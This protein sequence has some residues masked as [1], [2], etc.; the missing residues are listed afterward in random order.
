MLP[1]RCQQESRDRS[2]S[3]G[4]GARIG[5]GSAT[6]R[7]MPPFRHHSASLLAVLSLSVALPALATEAPSRQS[8]DDAWWTGP[9]I[10]N[11]AVTLPQGH[12]LIEPYLY[13]V[14][15]DDA[16]SYGSLTFMLYGATDALTVG[17]VPVFG[18]NKGGDGMRSAG[19][20]AA[21]SSVLLQYRL[22]QYREGSWLPAV[23]LQLQ[24]TLPTGKYDQLELGSADGFGGG[25]HSTLLQLNSQTYFW[26]PNG[27]ILRMR[28]NL[29]ATRSRQA[30]LRD[31]SVYGTPEGFRGHARPGDSWNV[32][33]AWEY[34]WTRNW[35]LA[36]DLVYRH[37]DS[38]RISGVIRDS[39][40]DPTPIP[41]AFESG[42]S[43]AWFLAPAVEYNFSPRFGVIF[44]A[45]LIRGRNTTH[46]V[47]PVVAF[48]YVH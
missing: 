21:D 33:A 19:P 2:H 29:G 40:Q 11:S 23:S 28:L 43:E 8:L 37:S 25:A 7:T 20:S 41:L 24:H 3:G 9:I 39:G 46:S 13:V 44:G 10:A 30:G 32:N 26:M 35:V 4:G 38:T 6:D 45:R 22:R 31:I 17:L 27:R 16:E 18:Y 1:P 47:T 42:S 12:Y 5:A 36:L 34:S 14:S 48:N 15:T